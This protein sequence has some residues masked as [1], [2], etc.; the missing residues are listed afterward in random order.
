M[1]L[2]T[3]DL[4]DMLCFEHEW[5]VTHDYG[6]RFECRLFQLLKSNKTLPRSKDHVMVRI[7]LD[8]T[9]AIVWK[10]E[11]LLAPELHIPKKGQP[12]AHTA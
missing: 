4:K 10:G 12:D 9:Y 11:P 5:T 1:P 3:V 7:S 2:G 6:V 8:G